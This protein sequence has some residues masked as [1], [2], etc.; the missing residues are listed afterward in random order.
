MEEQVRTLLERVTTLLDALEHQNRLPA[1]EWY[2]IREAAAL[3]G[4]SERPHS[5]SHHGW[6]P[7]LLKRRHCRQADLPSQQERH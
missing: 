2:S 1:Q 3:T 5:Q 6:H 4:L 7:S